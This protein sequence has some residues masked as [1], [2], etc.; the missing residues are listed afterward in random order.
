MSYNVSQ[1]LKMKNRRKKLSQETRRLEEKLLTK[2]EELLIAD[3]NVD[4]PAKIVHTK[5]YDVT[6]GS[7]EVWLDEFIKHDPRARGKY[8]EG[9]RALIRVSEQSSGEGQ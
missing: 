6:S 2:Q 3:V 4:L 8:A 9:A 7:L 1:L 5:T